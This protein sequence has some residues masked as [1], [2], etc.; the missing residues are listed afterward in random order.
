MGPFRRPESAY[1]R[2]YYRINFLGIRLFSYKKEIVNHGPWPYGW[3]REPFTVPEG[4]YYVMGDNTNES[5]DSRAWGFVPFGNIK[6]RVLCVWY[7]IH[8][9][10][11][12]K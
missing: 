4:H 9:W 2:V 3:D 1:K 5:L 6:G 7:P 8:R 12:V 10:R 11:G